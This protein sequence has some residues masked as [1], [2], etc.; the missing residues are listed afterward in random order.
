MTLVLCAATAWGQS[1]AKDPVPPLYLGNIAPVMDQYGRPMRGSPEPSDVTTRCRVEIRVAPYPGVRVPPGTNGAPHPLNPLVAPD[2]IGGIG[3]NASQP[4]S[5]IF[6]MIFPERLSTNTMVFARVFNAPTLEESTFY[7]DSKAVAVPLKGSS[8]V[9]EFDPAKPLDGGDDDGDGLNNSW[10]RFLGIDDHLTADYDGDGMIDLHEM[11]A[12]TD[13]NNVSSL[14]ALHWVRREV[15]TPPS[16]ARG[17]GTNSVRLKW[18]AVPGKRY[19][20]QYSLL[21]NPDPVTGQPR[22]F[23]LAQSEPIVAGE[24]QTEIDMQVDVPRDVDTRM[25]RIRLVPD[26]E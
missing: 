5:G 6:C 3:L 26:G 24:N 12:G 2:S 14:L 18:Q 7:A 19:Q 22:E 9:C 21:L 1:A 4:D 16:G 17:E 13:P 8:L 23:T 15:G 10:E 20:V 11:L 25:F